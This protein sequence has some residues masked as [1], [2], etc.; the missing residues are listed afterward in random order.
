MSDD[1]NAN[2]YQ[3]HSTPH[4]PKQQCTARLTQEVCVT[5]LQDSVEIHIPCSLEV[6]RLTTRHF[7]AGTLANGAP[8]EIFWRDEAP[9]E[10]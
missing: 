4:Q 10:K 7:Y 2:S 9:K 3:F 6:H 8:I 5:G 1:A